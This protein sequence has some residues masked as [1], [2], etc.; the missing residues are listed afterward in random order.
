MNARLL[1]AFFT[2]TLAGTATGCLLHGD[3]EHDRDN[4]HGGRACS[5][6]PDGSEPTVSD[7]SVDDAG[8]VNDGGSFPGPNS[9]YLPDP[10]GGE[11]IADDAGFGDAGFDDAGFDADGGLDSDGGEPIADDAGFNDAGFDA[12][13]GFDSD[14]GDGGI[15]DG[16]A[17]GGCR[18][19][20]HHRHGNRPR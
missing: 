19:G 6:A 7:A 10:D 9:G 8:F 12:D 4:D 20:R 13:G 18:D 17:G 3:R 11:P 15:S 16:G 14:G 5:T 2:L 1:A